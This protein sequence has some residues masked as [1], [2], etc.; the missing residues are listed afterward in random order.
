MSEQAPAKP[1]HPIEALRQALTEAYGQSDRLGLLRILAGHHPSDTAEA[2]FG[3]DPSLLIE[4]FRSLLLT[5]AVLCADILVELDPAQ[6]SQ[7]YPNL[8]PKEWA[9]IFKELSDD[10]A[11]FILDYFPD[12]AR[13]HLVARMPAEDKVEVL[14][15]MTYPEGTAGRIMTS[16]FVALEKGA[17]VEQAIAAVR[18]R[19]EF[20]QT[21]LFFVYVL[22]QGKLI[23]HVSLRQ[24]LLNSPKIKLQDIMRTDT[25][26][27]LV[28][29]DQEEVADLVSRYDKVVVPVVDHQD[30]LLGIITVDDV[31]DIINE[32][33]EEDLYKAIGSSDEELVVKD[34]VRKIVQ[35]RLPWIMASFFGS[36]MVVFLLK[37]TEGGV[38]GANAAFF[39]VFV[40]M[41]CAMGGN[42]G[43]QSSTIMARNLSLS[44]VD[45]QEARRATLRELKV[46]VSLGM[47][48]GTLIG[49]V[50]WF[51]GGPVM[52]I[53]ILLAMVCTMGVAATTGTLIPVALK[54]FG[55]DPA[56]AT[57]P[58]VTSFNDLVAN[59]VYFSIIFIFRFQLGIV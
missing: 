52:L 13:D 55:I 47:I 36:L 14:E 19:R 28:D 15:L 30:R 39:F 53:I 49:M 41:I 42:V 35:L 34:R 23:G 29:T 24:L 4:V 25:P 33:S 57:G 5:D 56:I 11:V 10:D 37:F 8:T 9:W 20:D 26:H 58:F 48:C 22:D 45:W 17:T 7:L 21:N 31:I 3:T 54:K 2:L 18:N 46:G 6:I 51:W 12:G 59:C 40:P 50:A 16:E 32:E 38:L 27:V 44:Y 43:V 1:V